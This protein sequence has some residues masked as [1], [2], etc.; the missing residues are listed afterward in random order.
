[1]VTTESVARFLAQPH[2][3]VVGA[4]DTKGSFGGA[5]YRALKAHGHHVVAVNP[6]AQ[7]VDG[8]PCYPTLSAVPE[9]LG[10][11]L[12]MVKAPEAVEVVRKCLALNVRHVWLF[13]GLGGPGAVSD[14][15]VRLCR[16]N[17][18]DVVEGACPFMFLEPVG[19]AH[20]IHRRLRRL[21]GSLSTAP[22]RVTVGR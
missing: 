15:A 5:V 10:G 14:E 2:I 12:V 18:V 21:N 11:V 7:S 13:K 1:M 6:N 3:T 16:E 20:R 8:D 22:A 17:Q 19:V 4:S 9:P